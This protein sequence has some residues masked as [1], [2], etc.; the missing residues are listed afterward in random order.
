MALLMGI[1]VSDKL[2]GEI[3]QYAADF[4]DEDED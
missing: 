3:R 4:D 1:V 2:R